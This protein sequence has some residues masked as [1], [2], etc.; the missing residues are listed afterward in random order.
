[1]ENNPE[2]MMK[3]KLIYWMGA[4]CAFILLLSIT[5][6]TARRS[7]PIRGSLDINDQAVKEGQIV[8]MAHCQKC[9]PIGESGLGPAI[10]SNPAPKFVKKFQVRH[11][12]GM[13][14][15]FS[16]EHIS[17]HDLQNIVQYMAALKRNK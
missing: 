3:I 5:G 4:Y 8:Y 10:N 15:A 9:H 2:E 14:P 12:L 13:M 16:E 6:C 11:G 17:D 7:E 1:M